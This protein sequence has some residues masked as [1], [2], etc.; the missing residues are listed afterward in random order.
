MPPR[1]CAP[2]LAKRGYVVRPIAFG[3]NTDPYQPIEAEWRITRD[4]IEVLADTSHP[5]DHHHQVRPGDPRHRPA[6]ADGGHGAGGGGG[7]D[8]LARPGGSP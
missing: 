1:C 7:L 4:C 6:R 8:H 2:E 5:L 3:T